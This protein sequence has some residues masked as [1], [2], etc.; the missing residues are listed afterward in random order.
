MALLRDGWRPRLTDLLQK[1]NVASVPLGRCRCCSGRINTASSTI[2][3]L[4]QKVKNTAAND[5]FSSVLWSQSRFQFHKKV[6]PMG[7]NEKVGFF[8]LMKMS[9]CSTL[10]RSRRRSLIKCNKAN[11]SSQQHKYTHCNIR[12]MFHLIEACLCSR[13]SRCRCEL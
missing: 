11:Y 3:H 8:R 13:K 10:M 5:F 4:L 1:S 6:N 9:L 7:R 2:D 12:F